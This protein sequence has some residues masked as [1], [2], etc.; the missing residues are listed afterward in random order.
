ML[1]LL[2]VPGCQF[3]FSSK[4]TNF[5][6]KISGIATPFLGSIV[7]HEYS[8]LSESY[9][10]VCSDPVYARLY[11][12]ESDGTITDGNWITTQTLGANARYLFNLKEL[13]FDPKTTNN[14]KFLVKVEGC[15][16]E[17]YKRPITDFDDKQDVDFKTTVVADIVNVDGSSINRNLTE[18]PRTEVKKL[19]DNVSGSSL[20]T[21][22]NSLTN[23]STNVNLFTTIFG[24][25]PTVILDSKPEVL[26][27]TP[28]TNLSE[29]AVGPF[30][31]QTFHP[32]PNYSFAYRWKLDGSVKST[33]STWNYIPG[34]NSQGQHQVEVFVGKNDGSNNID[35]SKPYYYK[36]FYVT[37]DNTIMPTAPS[38]TLNAANPS[39]T[40]YNT[41]NVNIN[42]GASQTN[43]ESFSEM[44]ISESSTAPGPLTYTWA[45][46][47]NG[48]Q[49]ESISI[50]ATDGAKRI[51]LWVRDSAGN[52]GL[53]T[54]V[55]LIYDA[56]A[57]AVSITNLVVGRG[58][59]TKTINYT[60]NESTTAVTA[61]LYYAN[62][63]S[64]FT[65]VKSINP[66]LTSTTYTLPSDNTTTAK[67]KIIA[68]DAAGNAA[69]VETANFTVDSTVPV[70]PSTTL[71]SNLY[72]QSTSVTLTASACSEPFILINESTQP[73]LS[74]SAWQS[75]T[76]AAGGLNYTLGSS[77]QGLHNLKVWA[78]DAAGNISSSATTVPVYYD[79]TAPAI[80]FS[81]VPVNVKG[82]TSQTVSLL[83]TELHASNTQ[84]LTYELFN[85]TTWSAAGTLSV[86]NGPL[87]N[88]SF[89]KSLALPAWNTN[90]AKVRASFTDLS[91]RQTT[92][93]SGAFI[94]DSLGP[95]ASTISINNGLHTTGNRNVLLTF[96]ASDSLNNIT[97]FCPK[98]NDVTA[99]LDADSCWIPLT[100]IS[101]TP[102]PSIS[103]TNYPFQLGS[104]QGDYNVTIWY[105][106]SLGNI[107][108]LTN[109]GSGNAGTDLYIMTYTPDPAPSVS[110]LIASSNDTPSN[111]LLTSDTTVPFGFDL[112]IRWNVT[113][114]NPI[115]NGN[116][117]LSYTTNDTT[118]T[119]IA[120]SLNNDV[121]GGCNLTAGTTGCYRWTAASP[122]SA[123]YRI[124]LVVS[125]SSGTP[126]FE[127][128]N[129]INTG[130]LKFLSG[131]TSLGIGGAAVNA[132]LLG[133]NEAQYNDYHDAQA[134][135]VTKKGHI[136][137]RYDNKGLVYISPEDGI[138]RDLVLTTGTASGDGGSVFSATLRAPGRMALD[139][140]DNVLIWD[141]NK[142][143]KINTSTTPWT[144]TTLFGGGADS[145]DGAPALSASIITSYTDQ[146][147]VT[148]NGRVYFNK[149]NEIWFY[150]PSDQLVKRHII[151][152]GLGTDDM[153]SWKATFDNV[154]CPGMNAAVAFNKTTS[155]I[156]KI[157]RRMASNTTGLCGS[158]AA[159]YPYYN[160]N[161]NLSTGEAVAPHPP[162]TVWSSFKFT[163]MDGNIYVLNQGRMTL[164]RY[165]PATNT[166]QTVLG[167][168]Q[169]GRCADG[170]PATSCKAVIM[171]AFVSEFGRI[172]FIDL[173]VLRMVDSTGLVQTI[174]G[175]PRNF[176]IGFN[177]I[178]A[179]YSKI[180]FFD[181][182]NDDV[183]IRNELEN[184]IVKFSLTGGNLVHVAGNTVRG[185]A[186]MNVNAKD[187][188]LPNCGWSVPCGFII[189]SANNRLYHNSNS[190]GVVAYIDLT[191]NQW[192]Q[193]ATGLQDSIA[194]VSYVGKNA[195]GLLTYLPSHYGVSG[196]KVTLRTYNQN[197]NSATLIYGLDSVQLTLSSTI[198]TGVNGN[199]CTIQHTMDQSIQERFKFDSSTGNW[200]I[201]IRNSSSLYTIPSL[202]GT[203]NLF[204]TMANGFIAYE[205][206]KNGADEFVFYCSTSGNLYK[207]NVATNVETQLTMPISSIK[208][209]SGSMFYHTGRSSLIFAYRQNGL[210]GI[211]E[212]L[213]P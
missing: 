98:Y 149:N 31:V 46:D 47:T 144:I 164:T 172:Y 187:T 38:I 96:A 191:T 146:M 25:P 83:M 200:L 73:L 1:L 35:T 77:T 152:T 127:V 207:R 122:T 6:S 201:T 178:S 32:D 209:D 52:V 63:G 156:T 16:G 142:V 211:A 43:C 4:G 141:Y 30:S 204:E 80:S 65:L 115:P 167:S 19:I 109:S 161:F 54:Y 90:A 118:Y 132:I 26:L 36:T 193:Q 155:A 12:I 92:V 160:T 110:N 114:N 97:A 112:Y 71:Y 205:H 21:A 106:D 159:T 107:S 13:G 180:N 62:D 154:A 101:E 126:I 27:T 199:T 125:D 17:V 79:S 140:E 181:V 82:T 143:R 131:N 116:I 213:N 55:D 210:Y 171:S 174:A 85:G 100:S 45:C 197:S 67:F 184:Q 66:A 123:Y 86:T 169:N 103:I 72:S 84:S 102:A 145:S 137:Y 76:L 61:S 28:T 117:S 128:S 48:T 158:Q 15:N 175:Q 190:G 34:R 2:L 105:K 153:A 136:F 41:I 88:S 14:V 165:N 133:A 22:L 49:T 150:D 42:T 147:T 50:S 139:Y 108:V 202:G 39:P 87:S 89:S 56:T 130:S 135:V 179:R 53:P 206:Y 44:S 40:I 195:D 183:Y 185:S 74:D 192:V 148:P 64:S 176:G 173:G 119:T 18:V 194:R 7:K 99:P 58:G 60:I 212:Y 94:I 68:S 121:N 95:T 168:T 29:L 5:G 78:K 120:S 91:G 51:Y 134:V 3:E 20:G 70:A 24:A 93:T 23:N 8:F 208:C 111:P 9:A 104:L 166:F 203:V 189:D 10:A 170:T 163:G 196:N 162:Q 69:Q 81:S 129:A 124:K 37:V 177:P 75:C 11:E 138:L 157:I 151:L 33:A 59:E 57:P 188:S 113:D 186:T 198:C 182:N